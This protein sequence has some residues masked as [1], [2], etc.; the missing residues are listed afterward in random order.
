MLR[1]TQRSMTSRQYSRVNAINQSGPGECGIAA[2]EMVLQYHGCAN[3]REMLRRTISYGEEGLTLGSL[4]T[5][6]R[7][8]GLDAE[9]FAVRVDQLRMLPMP[10]ILHWQTGHYVILEGERDD[11]FSI[12]DPAS[13]RRQMR[14]SEITHL[15]SGAVLAL[16]PSAS[17]A[18]PR[19][20]KARGILT[21]W[22]AM[23]RPVL[24]LLAVVLA[25]EGYWLTVATRHGA[26]ALAGWVTA[27]TIAAAS[28]W[29]SLAAIAGAV[30]SHVAAAFLDRR[31]MQQLGDYL[32]ARF[33]AAAQ[34]ARPAYLASRSDRYLESIASDIDPL[35]NSQVPSPKC[36]L[37][38]A[39][40]AGLV[41]VV[42]SISLRGG[43]A[44]SVL[45]AAAIG[46]A[47]WRARS[48][49]KRLHR[50]RL[51]LAVEQTS[52][53]ALAR[54][55]DLQSLAAFG[56]VLAR[57]LEVRGRSRAVIANAGSGA[58]PSRVASVAVCL[59]LAWVV[60]LSEHFL[61]G[62]LLA[63]V[64]SMH[65][66]ATVSV[67][68]LSTSHAEYEKLSRWVDSLARLRDVLEEGWLGPSHSVP[69]RTAPGGVARLADSGDGLV[70]CRGVAYRP[71][72]SSADLLCDV[73]L[74]VK[75][76]EAV[77]VV[78]GAGA[79]KTLLARLL[80]GLLRPSRGRVLVGGCDVVTLGEVRR[81]DLIGGLLENVEPMDGTIVDNL[82]L[83][84]EFAG[85][86]AI[87]RACT[88]VGIDG[89]IS[90]LPLREATTVVRGGA[91]GERQRRLLCLARLLV[92]PPRVVVLDATLDALE[93]EHAKALAE[94]IATLPSAVI[95]CTARPEIIPASY[96][97]HHLARPSRRG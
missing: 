38:G 45:A 90:A 24:A 81:R 1:Q 56:S 88:L 54:P 50:F 16:E 9:A 17:F 83:T 8:C 2:L 25:S 55:E 18:A 76:G 19:A 22:I 20:S 72:D 58:A 64:L 47:A 15:F 32:T 73:S 63:D 4:M 46:L 13:G 78:G 96:R 53:A 87:E 3:A 52:R 48:R 36:L 23:Q 77:A 40:G 30:A 5:A 12:V 66:L 59:V 60:F 28:A 57:W 35:V 43:V 27:G 37:G 75:A 82:C 14:R 79:G 93:G 49:A 67:V 97:R 44:L 33:A 10:A 21:G 26:A 89:W 39:M 95:L 42:A 80:L 29:L 62:M 68:T 92:R 91:F 31:A 84:N 69:V 34:R 71:S 41:F 11:V 7:A 86:P 51:M 70:E 65:L 61:H 6:A 85:S 94:S 74:L